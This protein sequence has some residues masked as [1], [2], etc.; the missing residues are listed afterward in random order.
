MK[1]SLIIVLCLTAV[2]LGGYILPQVNTVGLAAHWKLWAGFTSTGKVF[3]YSL[4][5]N[6]G[7][8]SGTS[9]LPLFPGFNFDGTDD[10]I[11][12][13]ANSSIDANG[14]TQL[15]ISA[16]IYPKSDGEGNSG[17]ILDK[18]GATANG[19]YCYVWNEAASAVGVKFYFAMNGASNVAMQMNGGITLNTWTHIVIVYN[20]DGNKRGKIYYNGVI[21]TL[22][23]DTQGVGSPRNDSANDLYIGNNSGT[24]RTFDGYID[25]VMI[26][27]VAKTAAEVKSIYEQTKWRYQE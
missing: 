24:T 19:Y 8:V 2:A 18:L 14:K 20:E 4:N 9:C 1:K 16:W 23:T 11:S 7:T 13:S 15:T 17:R 3:D 6:T 5:G 27:S 10:Y 26:F 12:V 21:Q 25:D 22:D